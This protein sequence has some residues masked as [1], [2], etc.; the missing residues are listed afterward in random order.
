MSDSPSGV[1]ILSGVG[2]LPLPSGGVVLELGGCGGTK[3][4]SSELE[5]GVVV[6]KVGVVGNLG[7]SG[8]VV[9]FTVGG[10]ITGE[11]MD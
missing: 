9:L 1:G 8:L 10:V 3:M 7:E 11:G 4:V 6:E 5:V 2:G